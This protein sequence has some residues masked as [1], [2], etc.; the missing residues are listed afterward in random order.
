[1]NRYSTLIRIMMLSVFSLCLFSTTQ[2]NAQIS[3]GGRPYSFLNKTKDEPIPVVAVSSLKK[4]QIEEEDTRDEANGL[5]P[6]F[7]YPHQV[8]LNLDNS[9]RWETLPNGDRIWRLGIYAPDALSINLLY[10][11]FFLPDES[12]L[13][14]YSADRKHVIGGFT[15]ANNKQDRIFATGLV[16]GDNI[17]LEYYLPLRN[18]KGRIIEEKPAISINYVVHGYRYI[19]F[20][21]KDLE[22][23]FS[24][25]G[26]CNVNTICSQGD[27]WRDQIKSVAMLLVG[28]SRF[29]TGYLVNN[30]AQDCRPLLLTANH[31]LGSA[32]AINSPSVNTW[33]FMWRYESPTCTPTT[34]G[35]TNMTTNGGMVLANPD[36]P[37]DVLSIDFALI[38]MDENPKA[39]G[40]DVYF[41][42]FDATTTPPGAATGIHHPR[43][44]VKKISMENDA[45]TGTAYSSTSGTATHWRIADWDSGNT[46]PGSSGSPIFSNTTQRAIG[47]LSGGSSDCGNDLSDWYGSIGYSWNNNGATDSR[48]RLKDHLDPVGG[49]ATTFVDGNVCLNGPICP[50]FSSAPANVTIVNS[51]CSNYVLSGGS[52]TAPGGTPCPTGAVLQY[53]VDGGSWSTILPV[54]NQ[55]GPAQAIKTRCSCLTDPQMT[56]AASNAVTTEPGSCVTCPVYAS[57]PNLNL[58]IPDGNPGGVSST[59]NV[60]TSG[61]ISQ[62]NCVTVNL[63]HT[64]TGDLTATL[65]HVSSGTSVQLFRRVN[66]TSGSFGENSNL[67]GSYTFCATGASFADA[68]IPLS[69]SQV[70]PPGIYAQSSAN[71]GQTTPPQ[72]TNTYAN[73][74]GFELSGD[75]RLNITDYA[76]GDLGTFRDWSFE[77]CS[78]AVS[79]PTF[80]GA[81]ANVTIVN[82]A[83]NSG[84]VSGGSIT[85]PGGTPCPVGSTLQYQVNGGSWSA[86]LPT[87]NQT[88]PAQTIKTRCSCNIDGNTVSA[89]SSPVITAPD[90]CP[91]P[92]TGTTYAS[93]NNL[94]LAIFDFSF[95]SSTIT[96]AASGTVTELKCVSVNLEHPWAGDLV[97]TLTHVSSGTSVQ[98]FR[99]LNATGPNSFGESSNLSGIYTFCATGASFATAGNGGGTDYIIPPG[100]Y[101]QSSAS[102]QATPAENTNTYASFV[103][104]SLGGDWRL[105][106][107]DYGSTDQGILSN[108]SFEAC[109]EAVSCPTFSGAPA[110]VTIVNSACNSG[111]VSG[112]SITVPVGTPCP[113]DAVLQ[114][115]VDGGSW[116]TTLPVYNQ[117]GPAQAIKT[118]CSCLADPQMTSAASNAVT[119]E[120][121][122]CATCPVYA[123]APNLNL[124][125]PDL[126]PTGVSSTINVATSGTISQLN[127]VTVNL[128]HTFTGDLTATLTHVSSGTSV[129]LFRRVNAI[130][131]GFGEDSNLDGSYTFCATGASFATAGNGGGTDYIIPP[132]IYAQSSANN[133][134]TNPPQNTNTY[135]N[136]VGL[137]L[138]GDWRLNIADYATGDLGTFRDWSFEACSGAVSCP[139]FSGAPANVSIVNSSCGSGCTLT[140][141]SITAPAGTPCPAGST[142]QY[143]V[144]N[145]GWT[146]TLPDYNQAG[147]VQTIKT[148]CS[149]NTDGNNVSAESNPVSTMPGTLANP[150]VP[151]NG[152]AI[153]AC[154]ALATQ[155]TP[156][157]VTACDGSAITPTGPTVTNAPNPLTCEGT[158]TYTWTYACGSTSSTWSFTYTIERNPFTLPA[159]GAAT[160][161]SPALAT[162]PTPPMVSSACGETLTPV[163]PTV[164][165]NPDPVTCTGT[166]TYSWTYTDCEGNTATWSFVYTII[167]N[168]PPTV[169]TGSIAA[170]YPSLAAA[171]AAALAATSATDNCPGALAETASTAGTCSAVITV[172]TTDAN[173]NATPATYNIRIDNT[174][175]TLVCK[176]ATVFLD[177]TGNYTLAVA[178]VF[179]AA[180][181]SDN[182]PGALTVTNISPATV[183]CSQL[184]QTVPVTVTAQDG[185]GKVAT[186]TAQ[187]TVQVGT[188]L[189]AGWGAGNT[190]PGS[191]SA[192]YNPCGP[193]GQFT[194][195]STGFISSFTGEA[196]QE[197]YQNICGNTTIT[198][199]VASLSGGGWAGI[200]MRESLASGSKMVTLKT[201][202]TNFVRREVRSATNGVKA[203]QQLPALPPAQ[204]LRIQRVGNVFSLQTSVNGINW[205]PAGSVTVSMNNCLLVGIFAESINFNTTTT[206]V[207]D[208][209]SISGGVPTLAE[210]P[211]S[212]FAEAAQEQPEFSVY[213]NPTTG[214]VT[215]D[216]KD[217]ASRETL[218]LQ[219]FNTNGQPIYNLELN[220]LETTT[221]RLD[222]STLPNGVYL[223]RVQSDGLSDAISRVVLH[224][225]GN[226]N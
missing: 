29:C 155:P 65:T 113:T 222:L 168:T 88:G 116:S 72:N 182:C 153:V 15:S 107:A 214:E 59:I 184:N 140:G 217:Y 213:P 48:R 136:F 218:R 131:S 16:Y 210:A 110:N 52:I 112:G 66:A 22:K 100:I 13:Y 130:Q 219:V 89:E 204:W 111:T 36:N 124:A 40:Y 20:D 201:Q 11:D 177:A 193:G 198:A 28:G 93:G 71:A 192:G 137:E 102:L 170:C 165:N 162:E 77:A 9:G 68:G 106:I 167:D 173:N 83:C 118:R 104:L 202:L 81:P 216:L 38:A 114:Y 70:I 10:N 147:P 143:N 31:C 169:T 125:I 108:W 47:F 115:Q 90:T 105:T 3:I 226:G 51:T 78:G 95:A 98:L 4:K 150:A 79:C 25:S 178:D 135:A 45:L 185:C 86:T 46:E 224:S 120:P 91:P 206:A 160:V 194:V 186:C 39:A 138:S 57:A 221:Q 188:A 8:N 54:Y 223:I 164:T 195:S 76:A 6:R 133:G 215:V 139:T 174:P 37:D 17:V 190:G 44:D 69:T 101:A 157:N 154:P 41:A 144:N 7:G 55:N 18:G 62:L 148:R 191:G 80:S 1:M 142:L 132:G 149:C 53:Q 87:Y 181:S 21:P 103:G 220:N 63:T 94:N 19:Q 60:A 180:A 67:D 200:T 5:P 212:G 32:D 61:T 151:V 127:C 14:I 122:S 97:A 84:T 85:A 225:G 109:S 179:N 34:D 196:I 159:N 171:E 183:N 129:Q 161:N 42:G 145:S 49:G 146:T 50:T 175:P 33:T 189:P 199:R 24:S 172:I 43:G 187:I 56:S 126:N 117:N 141:G 207:F 128:T 121:G 35:P 197:A 211:G 12:V 26:S 82:S 134:Q 152:S 27:N 73:F 96:V 209:V 156:P 92:C 158:R 123:S 119:T 2:V 205:S 166:R 203:T 58:A 74:V 30:T 176:N 208:N 75:W 99:R 23:D 64:F 163:G